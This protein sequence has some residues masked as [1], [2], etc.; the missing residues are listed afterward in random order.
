[1]GPTTN[2][3]QFGVHLMFDGYN[4]NPALLGDK[5]HLERLLRELPTK[6]GMHTITEPVVVEVG[7]LNRKDPGGIS[8]F[9][10]IAESH[11]SYHTFPKR[12]FVTADVY[13][14]QND[15]DTI[16]FTAHLA[17]LFGTTDY[18]STVIPRGTRYPSENT[19]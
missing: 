8:G 7:P 5:E 17:E 16:Q 9:V 13:T 1:M 14:C 15:L 10:L 4:A 3:E 19:Q 6:M 18:E 12:G 2:T 11:I